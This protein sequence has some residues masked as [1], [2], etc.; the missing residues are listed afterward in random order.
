MRLNNKVVTRQERGRVSFT[1]LESWGG[2]SPSFMVLMGIHLD[3]VI[4]LLHPNCF[5][6]VFFLL[7]L[8]VGKSSP[9]LSRLSLRT[10]TCL[11]PR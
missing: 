5:V 7:V 10:P 1:P 4:C 11:V 9:L 6:K 3:K 2:C 8:R